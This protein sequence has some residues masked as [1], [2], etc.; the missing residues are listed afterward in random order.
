MWHCGKIKEREISVKGS[1]IDK[2]TKKKKKTGT[3]TS[4][5]LRVKE[6]CYLVKIH[7]LIEKTTKCYNLNYQNMQ[8]QL[9][10]FN[11]EI[12]YMKEIL[13]IL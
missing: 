13:I 6:L 7:I 3:F 1:A 11:F 2:A 10:R 5:D 4:F 12:L 8:K 9:K